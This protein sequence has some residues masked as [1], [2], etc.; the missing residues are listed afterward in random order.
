MMITTWDPMLEAIGQTTKVVPRHLKVLQRVISWDDEEK[1][2]SWQHQ[3][4]DCTQVTST[5]E[6]GAALLQTL[7][8]S[9]RNVPTSTVAVSVSLTRILLANTNS[10]NLFE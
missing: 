9:L 4:A 2:L 8:C 10:V 3:Y 7:Y 6:T 5:A 1:V